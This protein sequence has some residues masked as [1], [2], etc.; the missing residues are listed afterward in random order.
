M[1]EI[2]RLFLCATLRYGA[3]FGQYA[4][5]AYPKFGTVPMKGNETNGQKVAILTS[6]I[7]FLFFFLSIT[8][9]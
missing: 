7:F 8:F 9:G 5:R 2:E 6:Q 4:K 3:A 1:A